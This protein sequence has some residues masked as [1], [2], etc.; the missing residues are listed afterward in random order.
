MK[1]RIF[2]MVCAAPMLAACWAQS[3]AGAITY[4]LQ[5]T[6]SGYSADLSSGSALNVTALGPTHVILTVTGD[7]ADTLSSGG[8]FVQVTD[9][10]IMVSGS[11]GLSGDLSPPAGAAFVA[12]TGIYNAK[13]G[14]GAF[15]SGY[16]TGAF[17]DNI[18]FTGAGLS[19]YEGATTLAPTSVSLLLAPDAGPFPSP[20][21]PDVPAFK[22]NVG[23][24]GLLF[25]S[26][27]SDTTFSASVPEPGAWTLITLGIGVAGGALRRRRAPAAA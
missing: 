14:F 11:P 17:N 27:G 8:Y 4:T 10:S 18:L 13:A 16:L 12:G 26:F 5:G 7:G 2:A 23:T 19:G 22:L 6:W 1:R 9:A 21:P 25:D 3:A 15:P 20:V 24:K